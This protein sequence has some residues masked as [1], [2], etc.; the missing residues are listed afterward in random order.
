MFH[1]AEQLLTEFRNRPDDDDPNS[2]CTTNNTTVTTHLEFVAPPWT[3]S[4]MSPLALELLLDLAGQERCS[5]ITNFRIGGFDAEIAM[6]LQQTPTTATDLEIVARRKLM[7][8]KE[9]EITN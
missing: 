2:T 1:F 6:K 3:C 4:E 9:V 8:V 5:T 7:R